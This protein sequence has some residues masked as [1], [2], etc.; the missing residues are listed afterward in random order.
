MLVFRPRLQEKSGYSGRLFG[1]DWHAMS[2]DAPLVLLVDDAPAN[3]NLLSDALEGAGYRIQAAPSGEVALHVVQRSRPDLILLDIIM[4]GIDGI[5]TCRR[6]KAEKA[7]QNIPVVFITAKE[8]TRSLVEGFRVGGVDYITKPFV[9]DEAL[10][11]VRTHVTLHRQAEELRRVNE[12]L[13]QEIEGRRKAESLLK[14][15]TD[16]LTE[17]SKK[18]AEQRGLAQFV[19]KSP[20]FLA[21]LEDLKKFE[22]GGGDIGS[23][24][25]L[26]VN[27]PPVGSTSSGAP[28]AMPS[29]SAARR[30]S[31]EERIL[32]WVRAQESINNSQ[33]RELLGVGMERACY[34]LRKLHLE[35]KLVRDSSG[36][37]A[38]YRRPASQPPKIQ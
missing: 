34:L 27:A 22:T 33:C 32:E 3:L 5:E 37:W 6:L 10:A 31:D 1:K 21:L 25:L 20:S 4:P 35:G 2:I 17:I 28:M 19:G 26:F 24:H 7:T 29:P 8:E 9:V 38:V 12:A 15:A 30:R 11:R 23:E 14:S 36:R 16:R 18:E 13:R